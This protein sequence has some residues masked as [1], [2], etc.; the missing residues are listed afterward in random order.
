MSYRRILVPLRS[1]KSFFS[2][3]DG[4]QGSKRLPLVYLQR[5]LQNTSH[6]RSFL[7]LSFS[8]N[9]HLVQNS[10]SKDGYE[11]LKKVTARLVQL[12]QPG[13]DTM[14]QLRYQYLRNDQFKNFDLVTLI[15]D[16]IPDL[17]R[18][19]GFYKCSVLLNSTQYDFRIKRHADLSFS[20]LTVS[21]QK[22]QQKS[23]SSSSLLSHDQ[24]K[25]H[26]IPITEPFLQKLSITQMHQPSGVVKVNFGMQN[27]FKQINNFVSILAQ[28]IT[29]YN[30]SLSSS[31]SFQG[32][33]VIDMG[34][35]KAYLTFAAHCYF[36]R[37]F[38]GKVQTRG[39]DYQPALTTM[40]QN[41]AKALGDSF[42]HL[43]F[44]TGRI[45]DSYIFIAARGSED[46]SSSRILKVLVAL[47]ACDTATDDALYAGITQNIDI[48]VTAPCCQKQIRRQLEQ[49]VKISILPDAVSEMLKHG[50]YRERISEMLTD[51]LRS[52][53]LEYVGYESK[54]FEFVDGEHSP[55]NIMVVGTKRPNTSQLNAKK[56]AIV[57]R[58]IESLM[59]LYGVK[60]HRLWSL[61]QEKESGELKQVHLPPPLPVSKRSVVRKVIAV[62]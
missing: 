14:L 60:E 12:K 19:T 54:V 17:I 24:A 16:V 49:H 7:Q 44:Y 4:A 56:K 45:E 39:V 37:L 6:E 13:P 47:H 23:I 36:F 9:K 52:M 31:E 15:N 40:N 25:N 8:E 58:E 20:H 41:T 42:K 30:S 62:D 26:L 2:V 50:I 59:S 10:M 34:C 28:L 48:L 46:S 11:V 21:E 18:S 5:L 22:V 43:T 61:I 33:N 29:S 51:T 27:K 35:G 57:K 3:V 1:S 53:I 38:G 55:K 32:L